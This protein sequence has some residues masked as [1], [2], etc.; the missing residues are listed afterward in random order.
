MSK[1][2]EII[3]DPSGRALPW[4]I[5][6]DGS[7]LLEIERLPVPEQD[8]YA[9]TAEA[10]IEFGTLTW[11]FAQFQ[12]AMLTSAYAVTLPAAT[13]KDTLDGFAAV[14]ARLAVVLGAS[15]PIVSPQLQLESIQPGRLLKQ[16]A[17]GVRCMVNDH[18]AFCDFFRVVPATESWLAAHKQKVP[19]VDALVRVWL[20]PA[21]LHRLLQSHHALE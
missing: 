5:A 20:Q 21:T 9:D 17:T 16:A 12:G 3:H 7:K 6:P 8:F 10:R 11:I 15:A 14:E 4:R 18:I 1:H 2:S 19:P 13:S